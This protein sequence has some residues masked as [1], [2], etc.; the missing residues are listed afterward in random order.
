M[1]TIGYSLLS[2]QPSLSYSGPSDVIAA[3]MVEGQQMYLRACLHFRPALSQDLFLS[4][5]EIL[6][7]FT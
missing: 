3:Q 5:L 2:I 6:G 1:P 4:V 7:F